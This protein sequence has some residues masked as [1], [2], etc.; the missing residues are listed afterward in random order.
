MAEGQCAT[1]TARET[2]F[3]APEMPR[4]RFNRGRNIDLSLT[5]WMVPTARDTPLHEMR[6]RYERDGYIWVKNLLPREDI[7]D[8]RE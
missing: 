3:Q 6:K 5:G 8:M 7:F 2:V 4:L 1:V